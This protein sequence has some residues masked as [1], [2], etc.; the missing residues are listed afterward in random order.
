MIPYMEPKRIID[1][2]FP[3]TKPSDIYSFGVLMWEISSGCPPFKDSNNDIALAFDINE[4]V[5]EATIPDTPKEY[6]E[7][8]KTCWDKD[9]KQRPTINEVLNKFEKMGFG[10]NARDK[11]IKENNEN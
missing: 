5:R 6:E 8:Y 4:G 11:P 10:I 3:Y 1:Q 2:N 9:P 7:L